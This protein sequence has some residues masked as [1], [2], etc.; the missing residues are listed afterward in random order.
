MCDLGSL[1]VLVS[2]GKG[3]PDPQDQSSHLPSPWTQH[4]KKYVPLFVW[5]VC[6]FSN[7]GKG[8][9]STLPC[10]LSGSGP[11]GLDEPVGS[12]V[13]APWA[14]EDRVQDHINE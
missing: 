5:E 7:G 3:T 6:F 8:E 10:W 11:L 2:V 9:T 12:P 14:D 1:S 13:Q 4:R